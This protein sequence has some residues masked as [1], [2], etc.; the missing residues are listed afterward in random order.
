MT[1]RGDHF[2]AVRD[3]RGLAAASGT[4][5]TVNREPHHD[6]GP[7]RDYGE[8]ATYRPVEP[9]HVWVTTDAGRHPGLLLEW[10]KPDRLPWEGHVVH[11]RQHEGRWVQ[12]DEWVLAGSIEK[13]VDDDSGDRTT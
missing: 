6:A 7:G 12:A 13:A 2:A 10:R 9:C 4:H 5:T 11:A 3:G 1:D 8:T